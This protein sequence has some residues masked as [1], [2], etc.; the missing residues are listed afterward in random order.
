MTF[1]EPGLYLRVQELENGPKPLPLLSGFSRGWAYRVL[2][3]YSPSETGDAYFVLSNDRN[4]I[5]FISTRHFRT[6]ALLPEVRQF[7]FVIQERARAQEERV[8]SSEPETSE[9]MQAG[10]K[11]ANGMRVDRDWGNAQQMF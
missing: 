10:S 5:W 11:P 8:L 4:E 3:I 9:N 7:R 1:I 6:Y 2:A